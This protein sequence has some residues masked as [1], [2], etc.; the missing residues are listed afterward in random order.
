MKYS[1]RNLM[2]SAVTICLGTA[3]VMKVFEAERWASNELSIAA[4]KNLRARLRAFHK[5][6]DN[7]LGK[8][9]EFERDSSGKLV[10][11]ARQ[12]VAP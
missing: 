7:C 8:G 12:P 9:W 2:W 6:L 4:D 3:L 5:E 1:L 10:V 11:K